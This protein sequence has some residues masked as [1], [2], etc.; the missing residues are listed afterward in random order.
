MAIGFLSRADYSSDFYKKLFGCG[1]CH[2]SHPIQHL[3]LKCPKL[4]Y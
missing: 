3:I 4:I 1:E 2:I